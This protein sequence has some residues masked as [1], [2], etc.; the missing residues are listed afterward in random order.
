M[1]RILPVL[2][3]PI[4]LLGC[5]RSTDKGAQ[6]ADPIE[7]LKRPDRRTHEGRTASGWGKD[8]HDTNE[9]TSRN[10]AFALNRLGDEGLYYLV[11]G[12]QDRVEHVRFYSVNVVVSESAFANASIVRPVVE[13][14]RNDPS[15]RVREEAQTAL[16]AFD[17]DAKTRGAKK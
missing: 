5:D 9:W 17:Q 1:S 3:V 15:P 6:K 11:R 2:A 10:A 14:L 13:T 4:L 16:Q 12:M 7:V 8:L